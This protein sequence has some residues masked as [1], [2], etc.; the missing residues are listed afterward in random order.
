MARGIEDV[1]VSNDTKSP[2]NN[3]HMV[4]RKQPLLIFILQ[5]NQISEKSRGS[6]TRRQRFPPLVCTS[7][8][9]YLRNNFSIAGPGPAR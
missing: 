7:G 3:V 4:K 9:P 8:A 2:G 6:S 5:D 1:S